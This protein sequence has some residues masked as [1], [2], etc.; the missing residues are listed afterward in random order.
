MI[1]WRPFTSDA[2]ARDWTA[3]LS[4]ASDGGPFQSYAWGEYKRQVGWE[5]ERWVATNGS[6]T[7]ICC[8]QSLKKRLPFH[9]VLVWVPGGPVTGFPG[10]R[11]EQIG[12]AVSAWLLQFQRENRPLYVRFYSQQ[13]QLAAMRASLHRVCT[14]PAFQ[15]NSG[16]TIEIDL[17]KPM[18]ALR[19]GMT[20][21]HRYYVKHAQAA[22]IEWELGHS[23]DLIRDTALLHDEMCRIKHL[24]RRLRMDPAHLRALQRAFGESCRVMVGRHGGTPIAGCIVLLLADRAFFWRSAVGERGRTLSA[25][26]AMVAELFERLKAMGITRFDFGGVAPSDPS[27]AGVNHFKRGFGGEIVEY[28]GEWEWAASSA[29]RRGANYVMRRMT[30]W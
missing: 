5:P 3:L 9:R 11:A 12:D 19:S 18:D 29:W 14:R 27:V 17:S 21:K 13:R 26:Y 20:A 4:Q 1:S 10:A 7:S 15:L 2:P 30:R 25:T 8:L 28:L 24:E 6:G 23:E 16:Y 22:G